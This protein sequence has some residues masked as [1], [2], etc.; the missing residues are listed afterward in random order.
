MDPVLIRGAHQRLSWLRKLRLISEHEDVAT[1]EAAAVSHM[2][3]KGLV[4]TTGFVC[5]GGRGQVSTTPTETR[6]PGRAAAPPA[7]LV[8]ATDSSNGRLKASIV[9]NCRAGLGAQRSGRYVPHTGMCKAFAPPAP[10]KG[11]RG[12]GTELEHRLAIPLDIYY[13][14][15]VFSPF[16]CFVFSLYVS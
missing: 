2:P 1:D 6:P 8:P 14:S 7:R 15:W 4:L 11:E 9:L 13:K 3:T 10:Q 12:G 16:L 5:C